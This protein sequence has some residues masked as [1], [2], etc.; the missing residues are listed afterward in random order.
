MLSPG[1]SAQAQE[2]T[3]RIVNTA[4][5]RPLPKQAVTVSFLY[6]KAYDKKIPAKY[7]ATATG[8][9]DMNGEARFK[10]PQPPPSHFSAEVHVDWSH[11]KCGCG[12]MGAS[13]ELIHKGIVER[14]NGAKKPSV[15]IKPVPGE[16]VFVAYPMTFFERLIYPLLKE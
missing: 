13:D 5:G 9:T 10:L 14:G 2:V 8:D 7:E 12:V 15:D 11:W 1:L 4:N 3:I 6:D 16:I